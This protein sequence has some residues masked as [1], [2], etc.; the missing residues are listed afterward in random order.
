M[1]HGCLQ[2]SSFGPG[3]TFEICHGSEYENVFRLSPTLRN[4][5]EDYYP[6]KQDVEKK[7][8]T[9]HRRSKH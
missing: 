3:I 6:R 7:H 2:Y 4:M 1:N 9:V 8:V 5:G